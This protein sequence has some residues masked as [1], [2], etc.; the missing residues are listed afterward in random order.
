MVQKFLTVEEGEEKNLDVDGT[1]P[2]RSEKKKF[3]GKTLKHYNICILYILS[4]QNLIKYF[5]IVK[6]VSNFF[7]GKLKSLKDENC[8]YFVSCVSHWIHIFSTSRTGNDEQDHPGL[9]L[10]GV[11]LGSAGWLQL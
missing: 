4:N 9:R 7:D 3:G 10:V 8:A 1:L 11:S 6:K 2:Q 5:T